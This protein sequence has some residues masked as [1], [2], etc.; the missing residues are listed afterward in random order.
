MLVNEFDVPLNEG[1]EPIGFT[2]L[3]CAA[4]L[5]RTDSVRLLLSLGADAN[6]VDQHGWSPISAAV[7]AGHVDCLAILHPF[8][9]VEVLEHPIISQS[10]VGYPIVHVAAHLGQAACIKEL[11]RLKVSI[12]SEN[13]Q[14]MR[15]IHCAA[16]R[17]NVDCLTTLCSPDG[18][19]KHNVSM[20]R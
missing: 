9:N 10:G 17:G 1:Y 5:G 12:V 18:Q 13:E 14:H 11:H 19:R 4:R 20:H 15:P 3:Y 7:G 16:S 8:T 6:T 2:P